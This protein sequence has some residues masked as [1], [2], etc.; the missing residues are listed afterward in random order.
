MKIL[1]RADGSK[2]VG[3][4]HIKRCSIIAS[5]LLYSKHIDSILVTKNNAETVNFINNNSTIDVIY[6]DENINSIDEEK[7]LAN[8]V[9]SRNVSFIILD[10]L[11]KHLMESYISAIRRIGVPV[12]AIVDDSAYREIDVDLILNGN[13]NQL[14]YDYSSATGKYLIGPNYFIMDPRYGNMGP[15]NTDKN[16][17]C[18]LTVGGSDHNDIIFDAIDALSAI[19]KIDEIVI[20]TSRSTG[21][22]NRLHSHVMRTKKAVK[23]FVDIDSLVDVFAYCSIALTAGGNTLFERI[24]SGIPGATIC[25]LPRQMEIADRFAA[26]KVNCNFGYGID[27]TKDKI[28]HFMGSFINNSDGLNEQYKYCRRIV[29]GNGVM[30]YTNELLPIIGQQL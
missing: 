3:M 28:E 4:G 27:L 20:V 21:Y 25:Q 24:A 26:L 8:I 23:L 6:I 19:D 1:L 13:P 12:S 18:L 10:L 29:G 16:I 9:E 2:R 15:V 22:I 11:E 30:L 17:R 14:D 5:Y 7:L